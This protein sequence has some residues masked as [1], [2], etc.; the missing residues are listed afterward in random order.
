MRNEYGGGTEYFWVG[1]RLLTQLFVLSSE[2]K[3]SKTAVGT[4]FVPVPG[5]STTRSWTCYTAPAPEKS[6]ERAR[7]DGEI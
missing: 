1:N 2:A 6:G 3:E 4:G 5:P 7:H